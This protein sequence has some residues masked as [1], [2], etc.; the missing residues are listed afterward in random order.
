MVSWSSHRELGLLICG[1]YYPDI[2]KLIDVKPHDLSIYNAVEFIKQYRY[3]KTVYGEKGICYFIL[4][5]YID[6]L[7][8]ILSQD[9][10]YF[11]IQ[12]PP[13]ICNEFNKRIY[14]KLLNDPKNVLTIILHSDLRKVLNLLYTFVRYSKDR[15]EWED[16]IRRNYEVLHESEKHYSK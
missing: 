1:A 14:D 4:H 7:V 16:R 3:V 15:R 8:D 2:D 5:H 12:P 6:R 9:L 13:D 11:I 10:S